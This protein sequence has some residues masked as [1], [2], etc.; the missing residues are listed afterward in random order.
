LAGNDVFLVFAFEVIGHAL[1]HVRGEP[2]AAV[3]RTF[4]GFGHRAFDPFPLE[5]DGTAVRK[6]D[7]RKIVG[8]GDHEKVEG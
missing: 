5:A 1:G 8:Q 6:A 3:A 4:R 7:E 2:P